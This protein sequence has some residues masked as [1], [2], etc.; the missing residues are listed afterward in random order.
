MRVDNSKQLNCRWYS[1][2]GIYRHVWMI[3]TD[4]I[5][6][7][8]WGVGITTPEVSSEKATVQIKTLVKNETDLPQSIMLKTQ[9]LGVQCKN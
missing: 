8:N 5:H 1:G 9:L 2:S 6:I 7:A 4:P 3:V